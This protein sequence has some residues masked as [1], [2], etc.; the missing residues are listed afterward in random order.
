MAEGSSNASSGAEEEA[1]V[2]RLL[3]RLALTDD[4]KLEKVL[5]KLL[6]FA[7]SLLASSHNPTRVKVIEILSHI[8]KRVKD[9]HNIQLP[10]K[11]LLSLSRP[12]NVAP[13]V[14]NF[15]LV[16]VE[17][18]FERSSFEE[19]EEV[20]PDMLCDLSSYQAQHQDLF[21]RLVSK[22][23]ESFVAGP[24]IERTGDRLKTMI[25]TSD[26]SI[27]V[28]FC[29][30][31]MLLQLP[32][33]VPVGGVVTCP[34]LSI[35]QISRLSGKE[36]INNNQLAAR[37]LGMLNLLANL[38]LEA[39]LVYPVF[40]VA[41]IDSREQVAKRG[42]EL[43]KRKTGAVDLEDDALI[44]RLFS[45]FLGTTNP[46]EIAAE[47][48]IAPA[49]PA[50]RAR[51][52][53]TFMHSVKA[54]NLFPMTL[55][56]VFD[57]LQGKGTTT[58]LK[59]AGMEFT[60][61]I[62]KHASN[63]QLQVMAPIMLNNLLKLLDSQEG[64]ETDAH[65]L[66]L[67]TFTFQAIGQLAQRVPQ[68]FSGTTEMAFR[69]FN[70][71]RA[72]TPSMRFAVQEALKS[73][74]AAYKSCSEHV[75]TEIHALLLENI[76][77]VEDEARFCAIFW[78]RQLYS[79]N[80]APSRFLCM[81]GAAD[82][83]LDIREMALEGLNP[84]EFEKIEVDGAGVANSI[85]YPLLLDITTYI[86]QRQPAL[87]SDVAVGERM[88]IFP[89]STYV[90]MIK[91]VLKC[92]KEGLKK[93][94][95][96]LQSMDYFRL[97]LEHA[98]AFDGSLEL[99][100][101]AS[102]ALIELVAID[103]QKSA[104]HY[105]DHLPWIKQ[106]LGHIDHGTRDSFGR[107]LG[108]SVAALTSAEASKLLQ[109]VTSFL[110][111][112][113][114]RRFE[115][116]DGAICAT[117]YML[118][119][120][121]TGAPSVPEVMMRTALMILIEW[122]SKSDPSL[123]GSA[124]EAIGHAGLR[125][126]LPLATGDLSSLVSTSSC[127]EA[128]YD[129]LTIESRQVVS[130]LDSHQ[131]VPQNRSSVE[132]KSEESLAFL[133]GRLQTLLLS[134]DSKAVQKSVLACGH[135]CF[136]V[137]VPELLDVSL[138][139]LFSLSRSKVEDILF[140]VGEA[141][142]FI[143]G[144]V[145]VSVDTMLMSNFVSLSSLSNFL[146]GDTNVNDGMS[147]LVNQDSSLEDS[148]ADA[149][150]KIIRKLLDEL[151]VSSRDEERC[152][153]CVWLVSLIIY[154]GRHKK[155]QLLLPEIQ[156]A[157]CHLL[158]DRNELTQEMAARGMSVVYEL[159]ETSTKD[160]LVK[161]LV[162]TLSGS[163][164]RKR[165]VKLMEDSEVFEEGTIGGTP[166]GGNISTYKEL[167]N[168]ANEMGQ[169]D[170][171]YKFM[172]LA[173]HQASLNSKRGAAFGFAKIAKQAGAALLPYLRVLVPKLFRYQYD[174]N[175]RIQEA[176]GHIWTSL[177]AEPK[178]VIQ[179]FFDDIMD[180]LLVNLGSRLW[181]S[182][183]ASCLA[184]AD[185]LQGRKFSEVGKYL[186]RVWIMN[187]RAMDDIKETVRN[188]GSSLSR[189][190]SSLST[191]L[192]DRTLTPSTDVNA[193]I[194]ILLPLL[195]SKGI[196]SNVTDV[197]Q[198][199]I[200]TLVKI[201]K[202][203]GEAVRPQ[204]P[205]LVACMLESLS[206][207]EDQRLSY[208][209]MH[210][211]RAGIS[212]EKLENVRVAIAKGSPMW[213]TLD[214]CLQQVDA[215]TLDLLVPRLIQLVRSGVGLN[216]RVGIAKFMS[217]LAQQVGT[218]ISLHSGPLLKVLIPTVKSERSPAVRRSFAA[219]CG[220]II[221]FAEEVQVR[222]LVNDILEL[223]KS[224]DKDAQTAS[225]LLLREFSYQANDLLKGDYA[226]VLPI[227]FI[228][229]FDDNKDV[230]SNFEEVWEENISS[231]VVA[232]QLYMPEIVDALC[233]SLG[234]SSWKEKQKSAK[235]V[236]KL[237]EVE[238]E[239]SSPFIQRLL[240][241]ILKELPG[242]LWDGKECMLEA[243]SAVCRGS[244]RGLAEI[245]RNSG[246]IPPA[247]VITAVITACRRNKSSFRIT[248]FSCLEE[249]LKAF[250][251]LDFFDYVAPLVEECILASNNKTESSLATSGSDDF[252]TEA[253]ESQNSSSV[254]LEK[255]YACLSATLT[256][257][258]LSTLL[259]NGKSII[260]AIVANMHPGKTW[261]VM[262]S[263]LSAARLF[264]DRLLSSKSETSSLPGFSESSY[265]DLVTQLQE[266]LISPVL[267][268]LSSS[269]IAQVH[270]AALECLERILKL[271]SFSSN[272]PNG[273][274][275]L[276]QVRLLDV[277]AQEKNAAARSLISG[278]QEL[279]NN[280]AKGP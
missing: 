219:A 232:M 241:S 237:A 189:V 258:P 206:S 95:N 20:I 113:V 239:W 72:E 253:Q 84:V 228:A 164:K 47:A 138:H 131:F 122:M 240:K 270:I 257:A 162:D 35:K 182:R 16:Y 86:C 266:S 1:M 173:N 161:L 188:A 274:V 91:F 136:G 210:A 128:P 268:C 125:G 250:K 59:Q 140:S 7:I 11:D 18:A 24:G 167:C 96:S 203:A 126:S 30:Q 104:Q 234:S 5:A 212:T 190:L 163:T 175:K 45:I 66:P 25:S 100:I 85:S 37:K 139:L 6:P 193:T 68:L 213:D 21:L 57:C 218:S 33:N 195:V 53:V 27:F 80:H 49:S 46:E 166:S 198:L 54:A 4:A 9:Q 235:A 102:S 111:D 70:A 178:L 51:L 278:I 187:F 98:M 179:E 265:N 191:R 23:L 144:D 114:K 60:V 261:Q 145:P 75:K 271:A 146:T 202:G 269:K 79:L 176:M 83:R 39:R 259:R 117:G 165:A 215:Q 217:L 65:L 44:G 90:A 34:G 28:E 94:S 129:N 223:Y 76:S 103:P 238:S 69:L 260:M 204:L 227:A 157:L 120:C 71:I 185:L 48:R 43:L 183:E 22:G 245:D 130:T 252:L 226:H 149:R 207:L 280:V 277:Q 62:F 186:E 19:R 244:C 230:S 168:L 246:L 119:Q 233:E 109:E 14:K 148:R 58:R 276:L 155:L 181:R 141:I 88:L 15:S 200:N 133:M 55:Q 208:V 121:M 97:L 56:C 255:V 172:D 2:E 242:R 132:D 81:L 214:T 12:T 135:L 63:E 243:I 116:L 123:A 31:F 77:A 180:D 143:W 236:V 196:L 158:G 197:R 127:L 106:F 137:A 262:L 78:A 36:Q 177:V 8:N 254:P 216:T 41:S 50:L 247:A 220:G 184:L 153:G 38:D 209:E 29:L 229:R 222:K 225:G 169:P 211:D 73:L 273:I 134:K 156:E 87:L 221:K 160:K 147:S 42:E 17:M 199:S 224:D 74:A 10:L 192:C 263:A 248:A 82:T 89:S 93:V 272:V 105:R 115:E 26:R 3:T 205:D 231:E 267:D 107:L 159:G 92:F 13:L 150:E 67:R 108:I 279:V 251:D 151:L 171:V 32:S 170:L 112:G 154:C 152:A 124:A 118:A 174:P 249:V 142:S 61:W 264:A 99:H 194:S 101:T 256:G 40:I 201:V 52:V 110:Q 64:S 275:K